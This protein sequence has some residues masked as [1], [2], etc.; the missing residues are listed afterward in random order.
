MPIPLRERELFPRVT[1][2]KYPEKYGVQADQFDPK[3]AKKY[4]ADPEA[5]DTDELIEYRVF[6]R[7]RVTDP[8]NS[9]EAVVELKIPC[10]LA[11]RYNLPG[12]YDFPEW[13]IAPTQAVVV[14][15]NGRE[16]PLSPRVLSV[17]REANQLAV[18]LNGT[19]IESTIEKFHFEW[20]GEDRRIFLVRAGSQG[21]LFNVGLMLAH[22]YKN[23]VDAPGHWIEDENGRFTWVY[24][25]PLTN[26][27]IPEILRP[28]AS[29]K[30]GEVIKTSAGFGTAFIWG[31]DETDGGG[32]DSAEI[33]EALKRIE[34]GQVGMEA[35]LEEIWQVILTS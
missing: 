10:R 19:V 29:L 32:G 9:N 2:E 24:V 23:G 12:A 26:N 33:I 20:R 25:K 27:R 8:E 21:R 35:K 31:P 16:Q 13:T 15:P 22:Q 18:S 17:R 34:E 7:T 3:I 14:S 4:W 11:R 30:P 28:I 1:R 5:P 6:D